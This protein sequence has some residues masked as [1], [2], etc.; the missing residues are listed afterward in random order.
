MSSSR[1]LPPPPSPL[2]SSPLLRLVS[3]SLFSTSCSPSTPFKQTLPCYNITE[4]PSWKKYI[5]LTEPEA[6]VSAGVTRSDKCVRLRVYILY[7]V[8]AHTQEGGREKGKPLC[9]SWHCANHLPLRAMAG[10]NLLKVICNHCGWKGL[11]H[12]WAFVRHFISKFRG[13]KCYS[14]NI[15]LHF[16]FFFFLASNLPTL[17]FDFGELIFL[18]SPLGF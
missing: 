2:L 16:F 17:S 1:R 15:C 7:S 11:P 10:T 18:F 14:R 12:Q 13:G 8:Q 6:Q 3:T 9:L 4:L 5:T